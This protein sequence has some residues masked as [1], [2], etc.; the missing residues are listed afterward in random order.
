MNGLEKPWNGRK[1]KG[2]P[3]CGF[4]DDSISPFQGASPMDQR[5]DRSL[6]YLLYHLYTGRF[7]ADGIS[8]K[9]MLSYA[10][11]G[12]KFPWRKIIQDCQSVYREIHS[13]RLNPSWKY[14]TK[15]AEVY[16][17]Q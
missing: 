17:M 9:C 1:E 8:E 10:F 5:N 7:S 11:H 15:M 4:Y 2:L 13:V 3:D 6:E 14:A 16:F 12:E